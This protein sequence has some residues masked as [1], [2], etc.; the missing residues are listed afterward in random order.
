M[1]LIIQCLL[2]VASVGLFCISGNQV[3]MIIVAV[4]ISFSI[5]KKSNYATA[6]MCFMLYLFLITL[7]GNTNYM[8]YFFA[9]DFLI[10]MF[11]CII[12]RES[13]LMHIN[14]SFMWAG[15]LLIGFISGALY[16][17]DTISLHVGILVYTL[18]FLMVISTENIA[19]IQKINFSFLVYAFINTNI[20]IL[21]L[22][23]YNNSLAELLVGQRGLI[24]LL[25]DEG[26]R[27]NT[28]GGILVVLFIF[29]LYFPTTT[30]RNNGPMKYQKSKMQIL[31]RWVCII[32]DI[33][34]LLFLQ[35]RGSYVAVGGVLLLG[36]IWN[37]KDGRN[38]SKY[39]VLKIGV[40]IV[41]LLIAIFLPNVLNFFGEHLV[42]RFLGREDLSNGRLPLYEVATNMWKQHPLIG[43]GFLQFSAF[44]METSDPHNFVLAYLASIG[45]IGTICLFIYLIGILFWKSKTT[46][47]CL[48]FI[49]FS[50][51]IHSLF[52]PVL[53]TS[54]P[55]SLFIVTAC[56]LMCDKIGKIEY[57]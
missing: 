43:N 40:W 36:V 17:K 8:L 34:I 18:I 16:A 47:R 50:Q 57:K 1:P 46:N 39:D 19:N 30:L 52:E 51:I 10:V 35:S 4:L 24:R 3:F 49:V 41:I 48:I 22:F 13:I 15:I 31:L 27:S 44:N 25:G 20:G 12:H 42:S 23:F 53:T 2:L 38:L 45:I 29:M 11:I 5:L 9:I 26:V 28:L 54:L 7:C 6:R 33:V 37:L 56:L 21:F 32:G 14:G 55:L